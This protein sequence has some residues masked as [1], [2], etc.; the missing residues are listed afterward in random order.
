MKFDRTV[1]YLFAFYC[2]VTYGAAVVFSGLQS[3]GTGSIFIFMI[4]L[5][6]FIIGLGGLLI[7]H[8]IEGRSPVELLIFFLYPPAAYLIIFR[9][10][11]LG[12]GE[13][14]VFLGAYNF[15][16]IAGGFLIGILLSPI[17]A[18]CRGLP[19]RGVLKLVRFGLDRFRRPGMAELG[20]VLLVGVSAALAV[21]AVDLLAGVLPAEMLPRFGGYLFLLLGTSAVALFSYRHTTFNL[22]HNRAMLDRYTAV[23]GGGDNREGKQ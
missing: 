1:R 13:F 9:E 11:D 8:R 15:L 16:A 3:P 10:L 12:S 2:L 5:V 20:A 23:S 7:G 14:W 22:L 17:V 21:A 6:F 19:G 18:L 4:G